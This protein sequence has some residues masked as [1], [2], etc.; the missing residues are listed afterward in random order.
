MWGFRANLSLW[1]NFMQKKSKNV[2]KFFTEKPNFMIEESIKILK[3]DHSTKKSNQAI[4][5]PLKSDNLILNQVPTKENTNP[6]LTSKNLKNVKFDAE[7][8]SP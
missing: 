2:R 8:T 5:S 1:I 4:I 6:I 7:S 3:T